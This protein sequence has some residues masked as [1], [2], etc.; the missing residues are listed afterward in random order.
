[1]LLVPLPFASSTL[2]TLPVL[3]NSLKFYVLL[4]QF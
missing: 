3:G 4:V 2:L 1:V